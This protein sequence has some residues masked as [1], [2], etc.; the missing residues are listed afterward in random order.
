MNKKS[1]GKKNKELLKIAENIMKAGNSSV[2]KKDFYILSIINRT[3][4]LNKAFILLVENKNSLSAVSILRMQLDNLLRL[5]AINIVDNID[6]FLKHFYDGKPIN[7]FKIKKQRFTDKFLATELDKK[8]PQTLDLYN[9][10]CDYIH[11]SDKHFD[12]TKTFSKNEKA[13]FRIVIGESDIFNKGQI[14]TFYE[15]II[16]ISNSIEMIGQEWINSKENLN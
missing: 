14:T 1:L 16:Y 3:I 12:A 15:N 7:T 9:Y 13:L 2:Q 10:L 6:D 8:V 5:N 4:S 11:F